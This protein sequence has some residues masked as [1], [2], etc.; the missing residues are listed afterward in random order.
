MADSRRG[1][2]RAIPTAV[3]YVLGAVAV[4]LVL[5]AFRPG[6]AMVAAVLALLLVPGRWWKW[7]TRRF[8]RGVKALRGGRTERARAELESFL[9]ETEGD[10]R[11]ERLQPWFNLGRRYPYVAAARSNLGIA[12]LREGEP[13]AARREFE[14]A[15]E[16]APDFA[17]AL[18]GLGVARWKA[19][20][21]EEAERAARRASGAGGGYLPARVLCAVVRR[22]RGDEPGVE[23][24]LEAI[25]AR[26]HDPDDLLRRFEAEWGRAEA[27]RSESQGSVPPPGT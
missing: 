9:E 24:A 20:R 16:A 27:D 5:A 17:E 2:R 4:V 8:R 1:A 14:R 19:G 25:R 6:W 7:R 18:Y 21:L 12:A 26:G 3:P 23:E 11:F 13:E 22:E 10:E 15:L